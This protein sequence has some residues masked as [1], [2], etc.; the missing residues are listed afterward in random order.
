MATPSSSGA[1]DSAVA[2][3]LGA[4]EDTHRT[5][6]GKSVRAVEVT[7]RDGADLRV[8]VAGASETM[9]VG[10]VPPTF[11]VTEG[12]RILAVQAEDGSLSATRFDLLAALFE[13]IV[14]EIL[15]GSVRIMRGARMPGRRSK[16]AVAAS[17]DEIDPVFACVG[18]RVNRL[19]VVS[20][21]L[22]GE[23][24]DVIAWHH[25]F[26]TYVRNALAPAAAEEVRRGEDGGVTAFVPPHLMSAA[27]GDG[28]SNSFLASELVGAPITIEPSGE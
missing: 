16:V 25:D 13:A 12:D 10:D 3:L 1:V 27:V 11:N 6:L 23:R 14:P 18:R 19:N 20:R 7:A 9:R 24:I 4:A 2:D 28:G 8:R 21:L 5:L 22:G 15:D 26:D 17:T